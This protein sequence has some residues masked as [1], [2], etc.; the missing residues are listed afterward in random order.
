MI[1][2]IPDYIDLY[3]EDEDKQVDIARIIEENLRRLPAG[4]LEEHF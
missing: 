4:L 1:A 2:Y 3:G